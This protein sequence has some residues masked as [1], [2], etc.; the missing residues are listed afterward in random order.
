MD[1]ETK[2][3]FKFCANQVYVLLEEHHSHFCFLSHKCAIKFIIVA[4]IQHIVTLPFAR[5]ERL[6]DSLHAH[7]FTDLVLAHSLKVNILEA[8]VFQHLPHAPGTGFDLQLALT[9]LDNSGSVVA[10]ADVDKHYP[11]VLLLWGREVEFCDALAES[12]GG[13]VVDQ[14]QALEADSVEDDAA[15]VTVVL[16]LLCKIL[17]SSADFLDYDTLLVKTLLQPAV[18]R[19]FVRSASAA[20][21]QEKMI[22]PAL[23]LLTKLTKFKKDAR[24]RAVYAKRDF[25]LDND[26]SPFASNS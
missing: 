20:P 14:P 6:P 5:F 15:L 16:A 4:K 8:I 1:R 13:I 7:G 24:V 26:S 3:R 23:R 9:K 18:A 21:N 12:H 25:T 17:S 11:P 22:T 19:R 2:A 10:V